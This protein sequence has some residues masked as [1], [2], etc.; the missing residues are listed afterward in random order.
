MH[1]MLTSV[2][3]PSS[4]RGALQSGRVGPGEGDRVQPGGEGDGRRRAVVSGRHPADGPGCERQR[5]LLPPELLHHSCVRQ[6]DRTN[7]HR[8]PLRQ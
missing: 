3:Y 5:A 8:R 4:P 7:A 2:L 1:V 6:H